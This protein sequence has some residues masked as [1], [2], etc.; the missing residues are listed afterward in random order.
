MY[1][2]RLQCFYTPPSSAVIII[3]FS[4]KAIKFETCRKRDVKIA[5]FEF[6][7]NFF[8]AT[9]SCGIIL[10]KYVNKYRRPTKAQYPPY[11][12]NISQHKSTIVWP[13]WECNCRDPTKL[14]G[15]MREMT[16]GV[17]MN[18]VAMFLLVF[19]LVYYL[20]ISSPWLVVLV[21]N[22][23]LDQKCPQFLKKCPQT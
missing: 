4:L 23:L 3:V 5:A 8:I 1:N 12:P 6:A 15:G 22:R 7:A 14:G 10:S 2:P 16:R 21:F 9:I 19:L 11:A 18:E 13:H 20:L 17:A